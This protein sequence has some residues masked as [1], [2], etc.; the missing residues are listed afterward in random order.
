[1]LR[2]SPAVA[3]APASASGTARA[4]SVSSRLRRAQT[5]RRRRGDRPRGRAPRAPTAPERVAMGVS[6][7]RYVIAQ[8]RPASTSPKTMSGRSWSSPGAQASMARA[9]AAAPASCEPEQPPAQEVAG[10]VLLRDRCVAPLPPLPEL[11]QVGRT[12]SRSTVSSVNVASRRS[13][14]ALAP[15]SSSRSSAARSYQRAARAPRT[16]AGRLIRCGLRERQL[17]CL[18]AET[19]GLQVSLHRAHALLVGQRVQTETAVRAHRLEQPVA[20]LPGAKQL[21]RHADPSAQRADAEV[22]RL[23]SCHQPIPTLDRTLTSAVR[24]AATVSTYSLQS[25]YKEVHMKKLDII[26]AVLVA[27]GGIN[28]GLIALAEFDLVATLVG[29]EF[30]ETTP[31]AGSCTASSASRPCTRSSSSRRSAAAGAATPAS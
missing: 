31:R 30:G 29:L 21:G 12:T 5:L 13:K 26:A 1:M 20:L 27:I 11:P 15:G 24:A 4:S 7:P 23:S 28:W 22:C 16:A 14:H 17:R 8:P 25:L 10:E 2:A 19:P 6:G 9:R 18:A 3:P